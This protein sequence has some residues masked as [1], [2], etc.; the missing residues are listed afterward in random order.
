MKQ[1]L[2]LLLLVFNGFLGFA[3]SEKHLH[4][5]VLYGK[6]ALSGIDIVTLNSRKSTTTNKEGEFS[7]EAKVK[8]TLFIISK[9][10]TD[11][12]IVLT[13]E[14]FELES[15]ILYLEQKPIALEDV[16]ILKKSSLKVEVK[17][18]DIDAIKLAKQANAL[19]VVNVYDGII[20]N[21]IDFVRMGKGLF[22]LFKNKDKEKPEN[23]LPPILFKDYLTLNFDTAFYT[24]KLKLKP[25]EIDLFIAYCEVDSRAKSL[26]ELQDLLEMAD[27]LFEKHEAFKKLER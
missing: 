6:I 2:L 18:S 1:I 26:A 12:R 11:R 19:K 13:Q 9:E 8:D 16:E 17:Q 4:G 23:A 3:Q 25:E 22:N 5:K 21:G 15:L 24:Q 20:E 7:I 14:L 27:F 10:Y